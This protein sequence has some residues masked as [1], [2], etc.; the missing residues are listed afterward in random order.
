MH[1]QQQPAF[2]SIAGI[3]RPKDLTEVVV[4]RLHAV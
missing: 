3:L 1:Y 4:E 2:T